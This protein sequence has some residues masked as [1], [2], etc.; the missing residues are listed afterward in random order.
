MKAKIV[1]LVLFLSIFTLFDVLVWGRFVFYMPMIFQDLYH[2]MYMIGWILGA[3]LLGAKF[4]DFRI[5]IIALSYF[6][7][8]IEDVFYYLVLHQ[9]L[10]AAFGGLYAFGI[11]DPSLTLILMWNMVGYS[12]MMLTGVTILKNNE[13]IGRLQNNE[14]LGGQ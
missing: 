4:K 11:A 13:K 5:S 6:L 2:Q 9:S 10:P 14:N 7:F 8:N 12:I 3:V 1:S